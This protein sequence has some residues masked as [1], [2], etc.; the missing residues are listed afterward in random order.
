[1]RKWLTVYEARKFLIIWYLAGIVGFMIQ[2]VRTYFQVLT[3]LGMVIAAFL[4]MF[5]HEPKNLKSWLV[6]SSIVLGTF[7]AELI[8]VN[9]ELIFG[10]YEYGPALGFL[11][12]GTPWVIGLNWLALIYCVSAL[13]K[14]IR[15]H[16]YFPLLGAAVLVAFDWIIE[17]VAIATGMWSWTGGSVP[18]KNYMDWFLI[19]GFFFLLI[20]I[21]KIELNNRIAGVLLGMLFVFFL[22]LNIL[23]HT[24]LWIS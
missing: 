17:P 13:A 16:W 8:G 18:V 7:L 19:S 5:F 4:L 2:P 6:F 3:P 24:P 21:F 20:R 22:V 14:P 23:I 9:T 10:H 12:W 1:M 15:D 11:I